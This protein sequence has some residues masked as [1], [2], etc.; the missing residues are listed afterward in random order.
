[1]KNM[2]LYRI[3]SLLLIICLCTV[4]AGCTDFG[5]ETYSDKNKL[6]S[7]TVVDDEPPAEGV[8]TYDVSVKIEF[9]ENLVLNKYDVNCLLDGKQKAALA[10]GKGTEFV[11]KL[12]AGEHTMRFENTQNSEVGGEIKFTVEKDRDLSVYVRT[13]SDY[14]TVQ[15]K[16]NGATSTPTQSADK[17]PTPT[18]EPTRQEK[19][20]TDIQKLM[21]EKLAFDTGNYI[22][23]DIPVGEYAFITF[24]KSGV[25]YEEE[26]ANGDILDNENF[27]TFGYVKVQGTGNLTTRALL[28]SVNAFGRLGVSGAKELYEV[29]NGKT[30]WNGEGFYKVGVDIPAGEYVLQSVEGKSSYYAILKGPIGGGGGSLNGIV[31]NDNFQG[32]TAVKVSNGQYIEVNR[33]TITKK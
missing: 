7:T 21:E 9:R 12:T 18:K 24:K 33:A 4:C 16:T 28:V 15:D 26:D 27:S 32:R 31:K 2:K 14:I 30:D 10:H 17:T 23:G 19:M 13:E 11:T 1:M 25:Y 5:N 29:I 20:I 8:Q 6:N 22:K 3:L